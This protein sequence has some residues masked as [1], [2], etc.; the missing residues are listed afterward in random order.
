MSELKLLSLNLHCLEEKNLVEKQRIIAKK[1]S[2][3]DIDIILLQEVAQYL[4]GALLRDKI[5][6]SNYG[7]ALQSL[8]ESKGSIYHYYYEPIKHSFNKYDEGLGILSKVPITSFRTEYIS[9]TQDYENWKSRKMIQGECRYQGKTLSLVNTHMGWTDGYERFEDQI[10]ELIKHSSS[11]HFTIFAGDFNVRPTSKEYQY[12]LSK[13]LLDPFKDHQELF[14]KQT[15]AKAMDVH[16]D[17]ARIDYFF[18]NRK[19]NVLDA[20]ILFTSP[21]VSDHYGVY[22]KIKL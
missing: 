8:L 14:E 7:L 9:K 2:D 11:Q 15:F 1:I 10:D 22:I 16:K 13:K 21:L 19:M 4:D 3:L 20:K 6:T 18:S 5:K 17:T 12:I